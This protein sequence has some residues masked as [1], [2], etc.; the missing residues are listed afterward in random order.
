VLHL[1]GSATGQATHLGQFTR[2]EC[3]AIDGGAIEG[4]LVFVAANGDRL[5]ASVSGGFIG[6]GV[7]AGT[8]T[9]TGGSGRFA[10][11]TGEV[12][13]IAVLDG[14]EFTVVFDGDISY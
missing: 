10:N 4:S 3:I 5:R 1:T 7:A 2:H 8:Y 13:F 14:L 9:F 6:V 11:A 12:N